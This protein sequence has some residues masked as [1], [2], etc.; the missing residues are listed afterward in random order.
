VVPALGAWK[1]SQVQRRDVQDFV[2]ELRQQGLSPSTILDPLRVIF[3]R[4]IRRDEI[5]IDPTDNLD[6]PAIRGRRDRIEPPDVAHELLASLPDSERAFWA[7]ALFCG[8][9]RG[10]L[11]GLQWANVD[12]AAGVVR[13][14]R[15]RDQV[16]GPVDVKTGAGDV[17][18][19]WN[20]YGHLVPGG[21]AH[22]L[23]HPPQN[24]KSPVNTGDPKYRYRDSKRTAG[25]A[26]SQTFPA[27]R[28]LRHSIKP[29]SIGS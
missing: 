14:E 20:G 4:A 9:C 10:E 28:K 27:N 18:Q 25:T 29:P 11:R 3:R 26:Q 2:D 23:V 8:L 5:S 22:A 21:E 19:T 24:T 17:R 12:F 15:S 1:L 6:L 13:V 16:E 7:V